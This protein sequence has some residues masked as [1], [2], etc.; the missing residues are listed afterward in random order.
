[1][2]FKLFS[3]AVA[4]WASCHSLVKVLGGGGAV[5]RNAEKM[6]KAVPMAS[7]VPMRTRIELPGVLM[8]AR[9]P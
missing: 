1:M 2:G 9:G 6:V 8:G 4:F 3:F 7:A 5:A